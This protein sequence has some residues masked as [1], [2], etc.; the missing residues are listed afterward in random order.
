[1][2]RFFVEGKIDLSSNVHYKYLQVKINGKDVANKDY[3]G[4]LLF[5]TPNNIVMSGYTDPGNGTIVH[6]ATAFIQGTFLT[7]GIITLERNVAIAGQL[8][9]NKIVF[10]NDVNGDFH[11]VP[12]DPPVI[13]PKTLA[14]GV[15]EEEPTGN[16]KLSIRLDMPTKVGV[17]FNYCFAFGHSSENN[18]KNADKNDLGSKMPLYNETTKSCDTYGTVSIPKEGQ[19]PIADVMVDIYDDDELEG[20]EYFQIY[21]FDLKA[22]ILENGEDHGFLDLK[23]LDNDGIVHLRD[24]TFATDEDVS[25]PFLKNDYLP[26]STS[27]NANVD[28]FKIVKTV[29]KGVLKFNGNTVNDG[30]VF[31]ADELT[32]LTF[33]P[34]ENEFGD[35]N[36]EFAYTTFEFAAHNNKGWT[37]DVV[38]V[39]KATGVVTF[40]VYPV[41]D[42][43]VISFKE[44]SFK[45]IEDESFSYKD[46]ISVEDV[47]NEWEDFIFDVTETTSFFKSIKRDGATLTFV[48]KDDV[49]GVATVVVFVKDAENAEPVTKEFK[50][51]IVPVND[52]PGATPASLPQYKEDDCNEGCLVLKPFLSIVPDA[53]GPTFVDERDQ[54]FTFE[55]IKWSNSDLIE[56]ITLILGNEKADEGAF[57]IVTKKDAHGTDKITMDVCDDGTSSTKL[58]EID[59]TT[60]KEDIRCVPVE[61]NIE[62]LSVNDEPTITLDE[63]KT[64]TVDEDFDNFTVSG[65]ITVA[66]VDTKF[67]DLKVS[68]VEVAEEGK[69]LLGEEILAT[70][71]ESGDLVFNISSVEDRNGVATLKITV[72]DGENTKEETAYVIIRPVN[73]APSVV[74]EQSVEIEEDACNNSIIC[75][76]EIFSNFV[77]DADAKFDDEKGQVP[78]YKLVSVDENKIITN[79]VIHEK[80]GLLTFNTIENANGSVEVTV[81]ACDDGES[82]TTFGQFSVE[83]DKTPLCT[84]AKIVTITV[85]AVNDAPEIKFE[86][87]FV[88]F[89]EDETFK[90]LTNFAVITDVDGD[91]LTISCAE[92]TNLKL[93]NRC[94]ISKNG[95]VTIVPNKDANGITSVEVSAFDGTTTTKATLAVRTVPVNDEPAVAFTAINVDEHECEED[96]VCDFSEQIASLVSHV[97][98][99]FDDEIQQKFT[100]TI[101]ESAY[102]KAGVIKSLT[103]DFK[104]G[105]FH[106]TTVKNTEGGNINVPVKVCDDG[107]STNDNLAPSYTID[108]TKPEGTRGRCVEENLLVNVKFVDDPP[109]IT[110][111]DTK[112]TT[113][114]EDRGEFLTNEGYITITDSD[115]KLG[116]SNISVREVCD[117]GNCLLVVNQMNVVH[118]NPTTGDLKLELSTTPDRNGIANLEI[119]VNDGVNPVKKNVYVLIAPVNDKPNVNVVEKVLFDEDQ[120]N[121]K[122]ESVENNSCVFEKLFSDFH[123]N[124]ITDNFMDEEIQKPT[125][126]MVAVEDNKIVKNVKIDSE[127]GLLTFNTIPNANGSVGVTVQACDDGESSTDFGAYKDHAELKEKTGKASLC[128]DEMTF[129]IEVTNVN[130]EPRI[131]LAKDVITFNEDE[132]FTSDA[133]FVKAE[134]DDGDDIKIV[135]KEISENPILDQF[136]LNKD[137]SLVVKAKDD[138]NGVTLIEV[139]ASDNDVTVFDTITVYVIPVNDN[140][141]VVVENVKVNEDDCNADNGNGGCSIK[142]VFSDF[143]P[144]AERNFTDEDNQKAIYTEISVD[145]TTLITSIDIVNKETGEF[146]FVTAE[147]ENGSATVTFTFCDDGSSSTLESLGEYASSYKAEPACVTN[148]FTIEVEAVNDPQEI[149]VEALVVASVVEDFGAFTNDKGIVVKDIDSDL[150]TMTVSAEERCDAEIGCLITE[151]TSRRIPTEFDATSGKITLKF[152]TVDDRNGIAD[153]HITVDDNAGNMIPADVKVVVAPVNDAPDFVLTKNVETKNEDDCNSGCFIDVKNPVVDAQKFFNDENGQKL[154]YSVSVDN[155]DL[156]ESAM[157]SKINVAEDETVILT[158]TTR[159]DSSGSAKIYV[160]L[161][162]NGVSTNMEIEGGDYSARCKED[163]VVVTINAVNDAP[164]IDGIK[165]PKVVFDEDNTFSVEDDIV[166]I[167]VDSRNLDIDLVEKTADGIKRLENVAVTVRVSGDTTFVSYKLVPVADAFGPTSLALMVSDGESSVDTTIAVAINEV[168]DAPSF[169]AGSNI[170]LLETDAPY[171]APWATGILKGNNTVEPFNEVSQ[172]VVFNVT[173]S[174]KDFF[175]TISISE[176]G[177][178]SF[179]KNVD[180]GSTEVSVVMCDNGTT[181]GEKAPLCTEMVSFSVDIKRTENEAPNFAVRDTVIYTG[182]EWKYTVKITDVDPEDKGNLKIEQSQDATGAVPSKTE[183]EATWTWTPKVSDTSSV[184]Y[185]FEL[186]VTDVMGESKTESFNVMVRISN[187]APVINTDVIDVDENSKAGTVVDVIDVK[188]SVNNPLTCEIVGGTGKDVFVVDTKT[189]KV[190]VAKDNTLDYEAKKEYTIDV[191]VK[192]GYTYANDNSEYTGSVTKTITVKVNNVNEAPEIEDQ[193]FKVAEDAKVETKV[194]TVVAKDPDSDKLTYKALDTSSVFTVKSNGDIILK[195]GLDYETITN[196]T[197]L[198]EVS[199]GKL[200]DTA[201]VTINVEDVFEKSEVVITLGETKDSMWIYPDTIYTNISELD[202]EW[203]ED[204]KPSREGVELVDGENVIIKEYKDGSKNDAGSDTLVVYLSTSIPKVIITKIEEPSKKTNI[205]TI[206]DK[207]DEQD[208]SFYV[209]HL[210]NDVKV[211]V[212]DPV[213]KVKDEFIVNV[214]LDTFNIPKSVF[215]DVQKIADKRISVADTTKAIKNV[216]LAIDKNVYKN[217][218]T[219]VVGK[220]TVLVSFVADKSGNIIADENGEKLMTVSC[221]KDVEGH[222]VNVSY[223]STLNGSVVEP[224]DGSDGLYTVSYA[225]KD[226]KNNAVDVSYVVTENGKLAKDKEGNVGYTVAYTYVNKY[227]NSATKSVSMVLDLIPPKV[228]IKTPVNYEW[229]TSNYVNV[230]WYVDL[231][232]GQGFIKQDSLA[233]QSLE[234]GLNVVVRFF[235]DKAGNEASDTVFVGV[236]GVKDIEIFVEEPV[237]VLTREKTEEYYAASPLREGETFAISIYNP[238]TETEFETKFGGAKGVQQGSMEAP[239]KG[240]E[241]HLGPT[242]GMNVKVPVLNSV[243][244]LATLD[245]LMMNG[246]IPLEGVDADDGIKLSVNEYIDQYCSD[247]FKE[248]YGSDPSKANIFDTRLYVKI[249]I[250]TNLGQFV[251]FFHFVQDVNDPEFVSDAGVLKMYFELKPG[252]DGELKDADGRQYAS[253]AYV[254]KTTVAMRSKLRCTVPPISA[255]GEIPAKSKMGF[256]KTTDEDLLKP[257]GYKRPIDKK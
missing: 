22:A 140:P 82:S 8:I 29:D 135:L 213:S 14:D 130:D 246:M 23:I 77:G 150:S 9:G 53:T 16:H 30:F 1:M 193:T 78:S 215:S 115:T 73:D 39:P 32:K 249:W 52:N 110:V 164:K 185:K 15:L 197:L 163:S 178:L 63:T 166:I 250:Y 227:G 36:K 35:E 208:T 55:N 126:K 64:P 114:E 210:N 220:D 60:S 107:T 148:N 188:D 138:F 206:V 157:L 91:E 177:V 153:V 87:D 49:N 194:G 134:D 241:G 116:A 202:I 221:V 2:V 74:V 144:D 24:T 218:Y 112:I 212:E 80:T 180:W 4:N 182:E 167:D 174:N 119:T 216:K 57:K 176:S 128:T 195:G 44:N 96:K 226:K 19:S 28:L 170:N 200:K 37:T 43:P 225:Y 255:H 149:I 192:D 79:V 228:E 12:F 109:V 103:V 84:E 172:K 201:K 230:D 70:L 173:S 187:D 5:Y 31:A 257:F 21:I 183:D 231:G 199:D 169:V 236:K 71:T 92:A 147:N 68:V 141:S 244:G 117:N 45:M 121:D 159:K 100:F 88:E 209:N 165:T 25:F 127:T 256:V 224:A 98:P 229:V 41:N 248:S 50:V 235:R 97:E 240:L 101:D 152:N 118:F 239:Y 18:V 223:T 252:M 122:G 189:C 247:E 72:V 251:D 238:Q 27:K 108:F 142:D 48:P 175:K 203:T 95:E 38:G 154:T 20:L 62:V 90:I 113:V 94:E 56:S 54:Q 211:Y 65:Y 254:Y 162:D 156:I 40:F 47:D 158:Y 245:D 196:Y 7:P 219:L 233:A 26:Y 186:A 155:S 67:S 10:K 75:T 243:G 171:S 93:V 76:K 3:G 146:K 124:R 106:L 253:G 104:T 111:D 33:V 207:Q 69:N 129:V 184:A 81:Q 133:G 61:F 89:N 242:L 120:C 102:D 232:D 191:V 58:Y 51:S 137:G 181:K 132:T 217:T 42:A 66:D 105:V 125:Y 234:T 139:A 160:K 59:F 46:F 136:V 222:K 131:I 13:D 34:A 151:G 83:F 6:T 123:G 168:N 198:V 145:N 161:C 85:K 237:T 17:T 214:K 179:E 204:G 86:K 99:K 143:K 190:T 11:Y 205:Y